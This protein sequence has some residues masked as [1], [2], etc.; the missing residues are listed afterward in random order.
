MFKNDLKNRVMF[1]ISNKERSRRAVRRPNATR[2][3]RKGTQF[4]LVSHKD[5]VKDKLKGQD[6]NLRLDR[7]TTSK[8]FFNLNGVKS[9]GPFELHI[10][11]LTKLIYILF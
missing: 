11:V 10:R 7:N 5:I 3:P 4:L 8:Y 9:S 1:R 6:G 2:E